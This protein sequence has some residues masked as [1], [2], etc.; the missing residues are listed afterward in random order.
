MPGCRGWRVR[1]CFDFRPVA[2]A[3]QILGTW[4]VVYVSDPLVERPPAMWCFVL[5]VLWCVWQGHIC[6]ALCCYVFGK[7]ICAMH[8]MRNIKVLHDF[9]NN[10]LHIMHAGLADIWDIYH[11]ICDK[12]NGLQPISHIAM[13]AM[14]C[15]HLRQPAVI[16]ATNMY[17]E[18]TMLW[19]VDA[20]ALCQPAV[21]HLLGHSVNRTPLHSVNS[22]PWKMLFVSFSHPLF[23][24]ST[25]CPLAVLFLVVLLCLV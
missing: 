4:W 12:Y 1:F 6:D 23:V 3:A 2:G 17:V 24:C 22:T 15:I 8:I 19:V 25:P 18:C 14:G 20:R 10:Q 21:L 9:M 13:G 5:H 11:D 16:C 7:V